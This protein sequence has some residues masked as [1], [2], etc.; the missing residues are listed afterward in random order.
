M[1][2]AAFTP[3]ISDRICQHMN[4]DHAEAVLLY[5]RTYGQLPEAHT[6]TMQ[7]IDA[8][9]MD[10]MAEVAGSHLPLRIL[11]DHVLVD[12]ED[13]HHTLIAMLKQARQGSL[14]S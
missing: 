7:A 8:E 13:A 5:A 1:S 10:L 3:E 2:S 4:R 14:Q 12:A 9:G 11:F 6:A